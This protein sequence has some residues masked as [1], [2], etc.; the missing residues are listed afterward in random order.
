MQKLFGSVLSL[1]Y[2][3]K[4]ETSPMYIPTHTHVLT[5]TIELPWF[6]WSFNTF[7]HENQLDD[8]L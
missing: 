1:I 3:M 4:D 6:N 7:A 5:I 2:K 8:Q